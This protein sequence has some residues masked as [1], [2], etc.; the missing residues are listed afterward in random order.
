MINTREIFDNYYS[1]IDREGRDAEKQLIKNRG[2]L[3]EFM[4]E[5]LIFGGLDDEEI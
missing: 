4:K 2:N 1:M 3:I 5:Y